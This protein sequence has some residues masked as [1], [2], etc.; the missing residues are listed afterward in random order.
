MR[1]GL[2]ALG[3]GGANGTV[4]G[5]GPVV[6]VGNDADFHATSKANPDVANRLTRSPANIA[7]L[8]LRRPVGRT[9]KGRT[10]Q[11]GVVVEQS[12]WHPQNNAVTRLQRLRVRQ[13][14][15][16]TAERTVGPGHS[17]GTDDRHRGGGHAGAAMGVSQ[18]GV[19]EI[20]RGALPAR[21]RRHG[22]GWRRRWQ[23]AQL[24]SLGRWRRCRA[25]RRDEDRRSK[26]TLAPS[27][28]SRVGQDGATLI[29][30]SIHKL[31]P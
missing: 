3:G 8:R 4:E 25:A 21:C 15:L 5:L 19:D 13:S 9:Q 2:G 11:P 27:R 28:R 12:A 14:R 29:M 16:R 22:S 24:D 1:H 6:A 23:R 26:G 18:R 10:A 30:V 31:T 17:L 20:A 7:G